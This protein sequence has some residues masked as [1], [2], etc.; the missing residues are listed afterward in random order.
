MRP[1]RL[2]TLGAE[3]GER[4]ATWLELF[5]DLVFVFAVTQLT[6]LLVHEPN[7]TGVARAALVLGV[8][9]WMFGGYAWLTNAV[10]PREPVYRV[11][12]LCGMGAFLAVGLAI[13][14]AFGDSGLTFGVA[15]LV[16]NVV[17]LG[18]FMRATEHATVLATLRLAPFNVLSALLVL[19][20]GFVDGTADWLLWGGAF[21]LQWLTPYLS[22]IGGFSIEP[23]HFV[24]RHGLIV[25]IAL[26]E[27]VVALGIGVG[28]RALGAELV[29]AAL[30]GLALAA[31]LWWLYFD[32][33]DERAE[34]ALGGAPAERR[35]WLALQAFG[36]AFLPML[37][38]IVGAAAGIEEVI[39]HAEADVDLAGACFLAGGVAA[40]LLGLAFF[41]LVLGTGPIRFR[42]A[43]AL[44]APASVPLG[45]EVAGVVEMGALAALLLAVVVFERPSKRSGPVRSSA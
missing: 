17:H 33:E 18:M 12:L 34:R 14:D 8:L 45:T 28:E 16:V 1:P 22:R 29:A 43:A 32:G 21:A 7:P 19:A 13:P 20:A 31:L 42:A 41:R 5:F 9:W 2:R 40:Y 38:G 3:E 39:G 6:G 4:R 37:G 11:L 15:Y 25:I 44:L 26:G 27:S 35:P 30:L 36:Y 23:A 24:E 10:P